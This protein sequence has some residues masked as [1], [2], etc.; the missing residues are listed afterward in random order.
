MKTRYVLY[1]CIFLLLGSVLSF[2]DITT[3]EYQQTSASVPG[4]M[5]TSEITING[6]FADLPTMTSFICGI[7]LYPPCPPRDFGNLIAFAITTPEAS[8]TLDD[9][10]YPHTGGFDFP[11]WSISPS[12][13]TF[14]NAADSLDFKVNFVSGEIRFDTDNEAYYPCSRSGTCY[15]EGTWVV[16]P[17]PSSLALFGLALAG[18]LGRIRRLRGF[19]S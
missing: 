2:A 12:G 7:P 3:Y 6:G 9:F 18:A 11:M 8:F 13:I 10:V 4:L 14:F 19:G 1:S 5:F 16:V 15:A 17:E